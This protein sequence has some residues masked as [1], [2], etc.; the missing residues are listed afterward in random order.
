MDAIWVLEAKFIVIKPSKALPLTIYK[1]NDSE[2]VFTDDNDQR[3]F[4]RLEKRRKDRKDWQQAKFW[5]NTDSAI[6]AYQQ[7]TV[8]NEINLIKKEQS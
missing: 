1:S 2:N 8:T 5:Q 7:I 6:E 3:A 4:G